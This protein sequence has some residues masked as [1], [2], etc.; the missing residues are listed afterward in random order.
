MNARAVWL[1][2]LA[3]LVG[4][5]IGVYVATGRETS[6]IRALL[7]CPPAILMALAPTDPRQS[8]I[9]KLVVPINACLYGCVAFTVRAFLRAPE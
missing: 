3:A 8:D 1:I 6:G 9:W 2:L 7:L 5:L 4:F